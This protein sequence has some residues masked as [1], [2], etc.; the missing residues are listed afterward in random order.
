MKYQKVFGRDICRYVCF[1]HV[2]QL[3]SFTG[4]LHI[5]SAVEGT[6][7]VCAMYK[8]CSPLL[9]SM[10]IDIVYIRSGGSLF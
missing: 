10:C 4:Y 9:H 8:A 3:C 2:G 1:L 5:Y 7:N 6:I